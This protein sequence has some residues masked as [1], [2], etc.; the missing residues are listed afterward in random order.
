MFILLSD[1]SHIEIINLTAEENKE[2]CGCKKSNILKKIKYSYTTDQKHWVGDGFHV[3]GLLRPTGDL[4]KFISPFVML[5]YASPKEF[6]SSNQ[7]RGV[8]E[9]P[10]RVALKQ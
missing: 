9:H 3:Y 1:G 7:R 6:S 4:N 8:G 2:V 10:H 5:D